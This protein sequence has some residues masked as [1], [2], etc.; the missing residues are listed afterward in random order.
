M[1]FLVAAVAA[2]LAVHAPPRRAFA[3]QE[4]KAEEK[5]SETEEQEA[6]SEDTAEDKTQPPVTTGGRYVLAT[7]PLSE[8]ERTLTLIQGV[9]ELRADARVGLDKGATFKTFAIGF[10][11]RYGV[12]DTL[13]L[14]VGTLGGITLA[15][16]DTATGTAGQKPKDVFGAVEGAIMYDFLDW[17][18]GADI[19]FTGDTHLS[20]FAGL[21]VKIR[22][23]KD[24]IAI[25]G[26]ERILTI[27]TFKD[28][29]GDLTKPD[30]TISVGGLFQVLNQL[31]IIARGTITIV[32]FDTA[33]KPVVPLEIDGQYTVSNILDIGAAF[34]LTNVNTD[35]PIDQRAFAVFVRF[36]I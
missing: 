1:R 29:K 23:L 9:I 11:G 14:Q 5:E 26:L 17:R 22:V 15:A 13:E 27:H 28:A 4:E 3:D 21:P 18:A 34:F 8:L 33:N 32:G 25:L 24:K 36:R 31:A 19:D 20:I 35:N 6:E 16:P 30:L 7:F 2:L 12:Q 10:L